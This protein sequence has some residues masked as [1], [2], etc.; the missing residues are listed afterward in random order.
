MR[1]HMLE[2]THTPHTQTIHHPLIQTRRWDH[3]LG[4]DIL[5]SERIGYT[6]TDPESDYGL[7]EGHKRNG[8]TIE[9]GYTIL[10]LAFV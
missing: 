2:H 6:G 8:N 1:V 5:W 4:V 7:R 3:V 9:K 10:S